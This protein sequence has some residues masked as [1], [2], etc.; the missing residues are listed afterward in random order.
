MGS[1]FFFFFCF[2]A[3]VVEG[4]RAGSVLLQASSAETLR[5]FLEC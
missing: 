3:V 1:C 5:A 2:V 4:L